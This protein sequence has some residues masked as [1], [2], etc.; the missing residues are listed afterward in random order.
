MPFNKNIYSSFQ[1]PLRLLPTPSP[2]PT[3]TAL[4]GVVPTLYQG[5]AS[6]K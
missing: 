1:N 6:R 5:D 2:P 4:L 3:I